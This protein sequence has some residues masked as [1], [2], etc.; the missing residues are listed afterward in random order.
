MI[1]YSTKIKMY[2]FFSSGTP[3]QQVAVL[4]DKQYAGA[5]GNSDDS[6]SRI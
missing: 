5:S 3:M 6:S 2:Y 4:P 1:D